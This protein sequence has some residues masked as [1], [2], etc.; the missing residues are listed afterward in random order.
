MSPIY[1]NN[2][3]VSV[4]DRNGEPLSLC[5]GGD[6]LIGDYVVTNATANDPTTAV[7]PRI[8]Y[9]VDMDGFTVG[10]QFV[11]K[12]L[13]YIEME[14]FKVNYGHFRV[15][16]GRKFRDLN[17]RDKKTVS[18]VTRYVHGLLF[19]DQPSDHPQTTIDDILKELAV[20]TSVHDNGVIAYK[21]GSIECNYFKKLGI[22]NVINL[23]DAPFKCPPFNVLIEQYTNGRHYSEME[24]IRNRNHIDYIN[25]KRHNKLANNKPV[26]C[27]A[28]EVYL[29]AV[30]TAAYY[31]NINYY[32]TG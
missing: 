18:Y 11:C 1:K 14:T 27:A 8:I 4:L 20:K 16:E 21:G 24:R 6:K 23:E 30:H 31:S 5:G 2:S 25:C 32:T 9:I 26:H 7:A 3:T 22:T 19:R 29:F 10:G 28:Q 15:T 12:E 13:A 17:V